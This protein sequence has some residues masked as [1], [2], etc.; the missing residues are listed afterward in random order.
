MAFGRTQAAHKPTA[1]ATV[2]ATVGLTRISLA[3]VLAAYAKPVRDVAG[4]P[5]FAYR[6]IRG[7]WVGDDGRS[8]DGLMALLAARTGREVE[9]PDGLR[10]LAEELGVP[11]DYCRGFLFGWSGYSRPR[12]SAG[13]LLALGWA[14][15]RAAAG[16]CG[17]PTG[18]E[19]ES[20]FGR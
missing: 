6:P 12:I 4:R 13:V 19:E 1:T 15:G 3:A 2:V 20:C 9:P 14:D 5:L 10:E 16:A 11:L 17:L 18:G 7:R 8:C